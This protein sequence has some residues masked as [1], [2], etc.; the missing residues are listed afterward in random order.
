MQIVGRIVMKGADDPRVAI[1]GTFV[2][3]LGVFILI[4][5]VRAIAVAKGRHPG[6]SA[7]GLLSIIGLI[8]ALCLKD[9]R[10][11]RTAAAV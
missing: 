3:L 11:G 2:A 7:L 1:G 5:S 10:S 6:W 8:V 9:R 4:S